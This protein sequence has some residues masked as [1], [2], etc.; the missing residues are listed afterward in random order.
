[1]IP[2]AVKAADPGCIKAESAAQ[3]FASKMN[4]DAGN[5]TA[6]KG[7]LQSTITALNGAAAETKSSATRQAITKL[8]ADLQQLLQAM[9]TGNLPPDFETTVA[10]DGAA[11]DTSCGR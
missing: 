4:A 3:A 11:L 9:D 10:N 7:D 8:V 5:P 2:H 6:M 1:V